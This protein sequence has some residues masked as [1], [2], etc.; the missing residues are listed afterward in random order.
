MGNFQKEY[1]DSELLD[2]YL[3]QSVAEILK[4]LRESK[5][6]SYTDLANRIKNKVSRQTLN[7]YEL[8][9]TKLRMNMFLEIAKAYNIEPKELYEKINMRYLSKLSQYMNEVAKIQGEFFNVNKKEKP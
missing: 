8:C 1:G 6:W 4:E 5:Q 2:T 7:N 9:K 3:N